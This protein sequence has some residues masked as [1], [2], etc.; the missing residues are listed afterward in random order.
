M[1]QFLKNTPNLFV[2]DV[3]RSLAFYVDVLGFTRGL[4]VP[5][6]PPF[7]FASAVSGTVEI[8]FND[9]AAA[10]KDHPGYAGRTAATFGNS[11]FIEVDAVDELHDRI[12]GRAKIVMPLV[13]QWYGMREFA[14]EDPDGFL[15]TFAQRV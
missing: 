7:V 15:I 12:T 10:L 2:A 4:S 11:M 9:T 3:S 14:I 8:F 13:T 1:P 5:D 6:E